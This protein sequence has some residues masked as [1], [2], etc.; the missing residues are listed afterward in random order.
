MI[1][2]ILVSFP[3]FAVL[4]P[5]SGPDSVCVGSYV[6]LANPTIGGTWSS[7]NPAIASVYSTTG[8][9]AGNSAG[10]ATIT[11]TAWSEYVTITITVIANPA[12]ITGSSGICNGITTLFTD[13]TAG[14]IWV[15]SIPTVALIDSITGVVT[16]LSTGTT[17]MRYSIAPGCWAQKTMAVYGTPYP[18]IGL[19]NTCAGGSISLVETY[20]SGYWNSSNSSIATV[21]SAGV[22]TG[23][24]PGID[25]INYIVSSGCSA[26]KIVTINPTC[27]GFPI[28]GT[29]SASLSTA[30]HGTPVTFS[31]SGVSAGCGITYQWQYSPDGTSWFDIAGGNTVPL[32]YNPVSSNYYHCQTTCVA[33]SLLD[34]ST[35]VYVYVPGGIATHT[36]ISI[37]DTFCSSPDFYI[38][39][40][41][42]S[43]SFNVTTWFGDGTSNNTPLSSTGICHADVFHTYNGPGTYFVKQVL[44][45]GTIPQDTAYSSYEYLYCRTLPLKFYLDANSNCLFDS[46]DKQLL[47]PVTTEIDSNDIPIDT[48]S[49]TSGLY[50]K[51]HGTTGTVYTF[52]VISIPAGLHLTCPSSGVIYDTIQST[53]NDYHQKYVGLNCSTGTSFDLAEHITTLTGR[54]S[55][56]GTILVSNKFCL[57]QDALVTLHFSP[58]YNFSNSI[59]PPTSLLANTATWY[60]SAVSSDL[61]S[62][63][64]ISYYL[65]VPGAWLLPGDTVNSNYITFG[66]AIGELDSS[67][68]VI[69]K[70]DT[71]RA[72][73][74]PNE[75][76]VSPQGNILPCTQLQYTI[77]FEN[78]G[79]DTAHN[80]SILD[81]LSDNLDPKS[82]TMEIASSVMNIAI[83]NDG[84]HNIAKFDLP[85]INLL[86]ST[87]T[88]QCAGMLIFNIKTRP[89][90]IDSTPILNNAGIFFDD[91]PAVT[92]NTV[93]NLVGFSPITGPAS[94]CTG[95][96]VTLYEATTGGTWT[97]SNATAGI[98]SE[99]GI[100]TG[101]TTGADTITYTVSNACG[102]RAKSKTITVHTSVTPSVSIA[103]STGDTI[104]E[105]NTTTFIATPVNGGLSPVYHWKAN[106][107]NV[108]TGTA[109]T[110]NP[111]NNDVISTTLTS[112]ATCTTIDTASA[113]VSMTVFP[114]L[115]PALNITATPGISIA[116]GQNDTLN[117]IVSGAGPTTTYQWMVNWTYIAGA[118]SSSFVDNSFSDNDSVTCFITTSNFC[119]EV[120]RGSF[121]ILNVNE[122]GTN[123]LTNNNS[124][125]IF[126]N[127]NKGAFTIKGTF[128]SSV[129]EDVS[130]EI[131][132]II[133][134]VVYKDN[135]MSASGNIDT[136]ITLQSA[137]AN[138]MYMVTLRS[139]SANKVFHFV[140]EK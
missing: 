123:L 23:I 36:V 114:I 40:C 49:A 97:C 11:Y 2:S 105:G 45:I 35:P 27:S 12:P 127:P 102:S 42:T 81:T 59:P 98:G 14:G 28:G 117:A 118:T 96:S 122:E 85:G 64:L 116:K 139:G 4:M 63:P 31:L 55:Q 25:S 112:N 24:S 76:S 26:T 121:I 32:V 131:T 79:N 133:G 46:G 43:S 53:V 41:G 15:S 33:S 136:Q 91:N 7:S 134:Q 68:N 80:I 74:D 5:I 6:T 47:L 88:N 9:V 18:I 115:V 108:A 8:L 51:A 19:N 119:N 92:T 110:Y 29:T 44:Y 120:I 109:Y 130:V 95:T 65:S 1:L 140:V 13:D 87:H 106:S 113:S 101:A 93:E 34:F 104:C 137:L 61:A 78:D 48:I 73:Y 52:R 75:I 77:R 20:P 62:F 69:T 86:D 3:T 38:S 111:A 37:P 94:V 135:V 124:I 100:V 72:S 54:H 126:P 16:G 90:L 125:S 70:N 17:L 57:P 39:A 67:N 22:A 107:A 129:D 21:N 10:T 56:A 132:D 50:Y 128:G 138:G 58:K 60:L 30:C 99:S 84:V 82:L 71:V 89:G 83:T 103:T 66:T